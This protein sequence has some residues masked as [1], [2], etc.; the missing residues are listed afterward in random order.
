MAS[1]HERVRQFRNSEWARR[2]PELL[3]LPDAAAA[4]LMRAQD[5]GA[6]RSALEPRLRC[7]CCCSDG[8][9]SGGCT[10][11]GPTCGVHANGWRPLGGAA[12]PA[13]Q[14]K[15]L[16]KSSWPVAQGDWLGSG[17]GGGGGGRLPFRPS[18]AAGVKAAIA[19][20]RDA[21]VG[22]GGGG[23]GAQA[24]GARGESGGGSRGG[25]R[26]FVPGGTVHPHASG[27]AVCGF[28]CAEA[29][30]PPARRP[31]SAPMQ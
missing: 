6:L 4:S 16:A 20:P 30:P 18:S 10:G 12:A 31:L 11:G 26:P 7:P 27:A 8:G 14:Q 21:F 28:F 15:Q 19:W 1:A 5:P 24:P 9:G 17:G 23:G 13:Q 29:G 2:F 3:Q 22:S 25:A